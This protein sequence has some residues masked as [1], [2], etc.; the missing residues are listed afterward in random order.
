MHCIAV[1]ETQTGK[2]ILLPRMV[3][4]KST[5]ETSRRTRGKIMYL[6]IQMESCKPGGK[7]KI[8]PTLT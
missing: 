8:H 2:D 3:T 4:D 5:E 6:F 7:Y 1:G